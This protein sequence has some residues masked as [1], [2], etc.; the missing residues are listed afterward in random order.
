MVGCALLDPPIQADVSAAQGLGGGPP[1]DRLD[2]LALYRLEV[3]L[4]KPYRLSFGAVHRY[5][6]IVVAAT[7][8]DGRSGFGEGTVLTGYTDETI[9]D[10]WRTAREFAAR[11]AAEPRETHLAQV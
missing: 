5:D 6:T 10:A 4:T 1:V 3:P 2:S 8:R 11:I 9:D 7:D